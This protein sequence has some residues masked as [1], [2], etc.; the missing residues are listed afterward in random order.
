MVLSLAAAIGTHMKAQNVTIILC[1]W[2]YSLQICAQIGGHAFFRNLTIQDGLP[3]SDV[4]AITQD[5]HRYMW[6]GTANGLCRYDGYTMQNLTY[7]KDGIPLLQ[8]NFVTALEWVN[9]STLAIGTFETGL[10]FLNIYSFESR[11]FQDT[12]MPKSISNNRILFLKKDSKGI[13]WIGAHGVGLDYYDT[14]QEKFGSIDFKPKGIQTIPPSAINIIHDIVEHPGNPDKL[15]LG[16]LNGLIELDRHTGRYASHYLSDTRFAEDV[17]VLSNRIRSLLFLSPN[18]ILVGSWGGGVIRYDLEKR[19]AQNFFPD[20]RASFSGARNVVRQLCESNGHIWVATHDFGIGLF[21]ANKGFHFF[22]SDQFFPGAPLKAEFTGVYEDISGD[23]WFMSYKGISLWQKKSQKFK[24]IRLDT[25]KNNF[26]PR[27]FSVLT[28]CP[29]N[30]PNEYF[31]GTWVGDGLYLLDAVQYTTRLIPMNSIQNPVVTINGIVPINGSEFY[32]GTLDDGLHIYDHVTEKSKPIPYKN[33]E[34]NA[35][36]PRIRS[37]TKDKDGGIYISTANIGVLY[38]HAAK[39]WKNIVTRGQEID[40]I[41]VGVVTKVAL[42][43]HGR[44][45]FTS[46]AGVMIYEP[47]NNEFRRLGVHNGYPDSFRRILDLYFDEADR[48]WV[49]T[50]SRGVYALNQNLEVV[51]HWSIKNGLNNDFVN[52]ISSDTRGNIIVSSLR[53]LNIFHPVLRKISFFHSGNGLMIDNSIGDIL[54]HEGKFLMGTESGLFLADMLDLTQNNPCSIELTQV[55]PDPTSS[56][57]TSKG[58]VFYFPY[59]NNSITF[60]FNDFNYDVVHSS[61]FRYQLHGLDTS[62]L[63]TVEGQNRVTYQR[64]KPGPYR[65]E[66]TVLCQDGQ[67]NSDGIVYDFVIEQAFWEKWWVRVSLFLMISAPLYWTYTTRVK[68]QKAK[69]E[70]EHKLKYLQSESLR[71]QMNPHFLFNSLNSIRYYIQSQD[72]KSAI[73]YLNKFG[74]L[75]RLILDYTRSSTISLAQEIEITQLYVDLEKRRFDN[76]FEFHL[77]VDPEI[78]TTDIQI[79]PLITQPFVENAIWHGLMHKS[80]QGVLNYGLYLRENIIQILIRDNGVG[81][82]YTE[83]NLDTKTFKRK[84]HGMKITEERINNFNQMHAQSLS[85]VV[86]DLMDEMGKPTGTEVNISLKIK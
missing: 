83:P 14:R 1:S 74:Q 35:I 15:W 12:D 21:N 42:S 11:H 78:I 9:D 30:N 33:V 63:Y 81:R 68:S 6:I 56:H 80:G 22:N 49:A 54:I 16:T 85:V 82:S 19:N 61:R 31:L 65:F 36:I 52:R 8:G 50:E 24:Y 73:A 66:V 29:T 10:T 59:D 25:P 69:L 64:L 55:S 47:Y 70:M 13:L 75:I 17:S 67:Y 18:I 5:K 58:T 76:K 62:Y 40:G 41:K 84:S 72:N 77:Y 2:L 26:S 44:I 32:I 57:T 46:E 38:Y 71:A 86:I 28:M 37:M 45:A 4:T 20:S 53:G 48:L 43:A 39:G 60:T 51:E 7:R 23:L 27:I 3:S 79:P 34:G